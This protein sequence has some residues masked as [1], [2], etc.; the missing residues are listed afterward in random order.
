MNY[1]ASI[2]IEGIKKVYEATSES[3]SLVRNLGVNI[4]NQIGPLKGLL[5]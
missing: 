4:I 5:I 2:G 1:T 3:L